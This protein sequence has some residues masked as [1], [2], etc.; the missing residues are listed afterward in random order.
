MIACN[1]LQRQKWRYDPKA[2]VIVHK[3]SR[4]CLDLPSRRG[5]QGVTL[6]RCHGGSS[7]RWL[8]EPVDWKK[9]A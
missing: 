9:L 2:Q 8:M 5:P 6:Q 1:D 3:T 7:Q 4:M